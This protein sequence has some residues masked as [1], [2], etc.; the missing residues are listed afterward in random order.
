MRY[1]W[2]VTGVLFGALVALVVTYTLQE[3]RPTPPIWNG[4]IPA[5]T[6]DSTWV[7]PPHIGTIQQ[8]MG[9]KNYRLWI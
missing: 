2:F 5:V 1:L 4:K 7:A 8:R 3:V 9:R 6:M